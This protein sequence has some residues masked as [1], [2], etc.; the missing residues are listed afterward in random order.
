MTRTRGFS[1]TIN[2]NQMT[3]PYK[4]NLPAKS[5]SEADQKA[6]ALAKLASQLDGKSLAALAR[7]GKSFLSHPVYG[8][9]VRKHLGI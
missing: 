9:M 1:H 2:L 7:K 6:E 8:G 5:Q 3:Y 4:L